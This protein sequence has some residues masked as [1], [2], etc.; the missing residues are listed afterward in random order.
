MLDIKSIHAFLNDI[1]SP[2]N[3]KDIAVNGIQVENEAV[4]KKI[5]FAVDASL[6]TIELAAENKSNLLIVHHGF[7]WNRQNTITGIFKKRIKM[8][9][10]SDI[11][12]IAYHLPLDAH[13]EYGNNIQILKK[14]DL[15]KKEFKPFGFY[16][17]EHIGWQTELNNPL[18]IEKII[19]LIEI[20]NHSYKF[21]D[22]GKKEIKK[23][24]VVSG[25][26]DFAFDEAVTCGLD[27]FITGDSSHVLYHSAK[28][29]K[30]NI[31]FAGHYFTE[32]FGIL[33]IKKL[34]EE[35]FNI[36]AEFLNIPTGL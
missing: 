10:D 13:N 11:G 8:L 31:L 1:L 19:E 32:T 3:F 27:L 23:I 36:T 30:I 35:K 34:V 16:H 24:G 21:L 28:E 17:G 20:K 25:G 22:F 26:G 5:S 12:L 2:D 4:I 33:A 7:Y 9:L 29:N 18:S 6:E 14:F 15:E